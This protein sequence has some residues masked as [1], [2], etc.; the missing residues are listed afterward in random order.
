MLGPESLVAHKILV[1]QTDGRIMEALRLCRNDK[2]Q[3]TN[4]RLADG[5]F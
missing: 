3:T 4:D 2:Y 1:K 5:N